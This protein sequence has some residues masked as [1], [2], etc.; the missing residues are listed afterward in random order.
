MVDKNIYDS[1]RVYFKYLPYIA[2]DFPKEA[3]KSALA[4]LHLT[5]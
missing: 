4:L 1:I 2:K 5:K 3:E